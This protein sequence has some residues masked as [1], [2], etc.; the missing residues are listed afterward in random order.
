MFQCE[1]CS[2]TYSRKSDLTKHRRSTHYDYEE[3][4]ELFK[5][6]NEADS[7]FFSLKKLFDKQKLRNEYLETTVMNLL[8][9]NKQLAS[10]NDQLIIEINKIKSNDRTTTKENK[11]V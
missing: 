10:V 7:L 6:S 9:Q 8:Q 11:Y 2:K 1:V 5:S 3:E 4:T